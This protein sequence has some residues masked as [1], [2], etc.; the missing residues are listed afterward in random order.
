MSYANRCGE[1]TYYEMPKNKYEKGYCEYYRAYYYPEDSC[2]HQTS[3][4]NPS[5]CYITTMVCNVL[6]LNDDNEV[7]TT[8]RNFRNNV[9]QQNISYLPILMEYDVIGP[10]I[11]QAIEE[12]YK[13][14]KD[15]TLSREMYKNYLLK[16]KELILEKNYQ[17]AINKYQEMTNIL[18]KYYGITTKEQ[19]IENYDQKLGGHGKVYLKTVEVK[20]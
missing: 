2:S 14:D 19:L 4:S 17:K 3:I 5:T 18:K 12:D 8:L 11:A 16:T 15:Q 20:K 9:L 10:Q 1:C 6:G 7:L 13:K